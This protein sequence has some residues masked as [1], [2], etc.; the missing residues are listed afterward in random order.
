M[1]D[2]RLALA[3]VIAVQGR[4]DESAQWFDPARQVLDAQRAR[5]LRAIVDHDHGLV[6]IRMGHRDA[7]TLC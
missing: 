6:E 1:A 2:L 3:R 7:A 5:P 4:L